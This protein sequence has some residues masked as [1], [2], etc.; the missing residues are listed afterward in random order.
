MED[1]MVSVLKLSVA[2]IIKDI[3]FDFIDNSALNLITELTAETLE[4]SSK[5]IN[6]HLSI[7]FPHNSLK[8]NDAFTISCFS[9]TLKKLNLEINELVEYVEL[10]KSNYT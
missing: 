1:Y 2:Q 5:D 8:F 4:N 3:G 9:L 10:V 6:S 7:N